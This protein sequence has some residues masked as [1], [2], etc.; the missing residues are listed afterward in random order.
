MNNGAIDD[1]VEF[2][3][4]PAVLNTDST[5]T[6]TGLTARLILAISKRIG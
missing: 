3:M 4:L 5:G 6:L 1:L 2:S